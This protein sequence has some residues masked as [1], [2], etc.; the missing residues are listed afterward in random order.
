MTNLEALQSLI[1]YRENEDRFIKALLDRSI[2]PYIQYV[3]ASKADIDLAAVDIIQFLLSHPDFK[4]GDTEIKYDKAALKSLQSEILAKY[5]Q[6]L[7]IISG[8][9][10]W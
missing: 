5:D 6:S 7:P 4:E 10:L 1:E 3:A 2:N 9:Q 8:V